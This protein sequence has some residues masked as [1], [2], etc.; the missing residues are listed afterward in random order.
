MVAKRFQILTYPPSIFR[1]FFLSCFYLF[2]ER[3]SLVRFH[4]FWIM[5]ILFYYVLKIFSSGFS[6]LCLIFISK[7]TKGFT[8]FFILIFY[9]GSVSFSLIT[10]RISGVIHGSV[11]YLPRTS[12]IGATK[13]NT[14][15]K[16]FFLIF[17]MTRSNSF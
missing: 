12:F 5:M 10:P 16:M 15:L 14:R 8:F 7:L 13:S 11:H 2:F 9:V 3:M 4:T 1:Q 6:Y 17:S